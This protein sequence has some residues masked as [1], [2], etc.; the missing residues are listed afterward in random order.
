MLAGIATALLRP[1]R[2]DD[3]RTV[4]TWSRSWLTG[5]LLYAAGPTDTVDYPPWAI[6]I[7]TPLTLIPDAGL[8]LA[9]A[10]LHVILAPLL[11]YLTL[12]ALFPDAPPRYAIVPMLMFLLWDG[13]W[14]TLQ[15]SHVTMI[16]ALLAMIYSERRPWLSGALL[17]LALTKPNIS[18]PFLLWIL[19]MRRYRTAA[20]AGATVL[21]GLATFSIGVHRDPGAVLA[22][23]FGDLRILYAGINPAVGMTGL[24]WFFEALVPVPA[25]TAIMGMVGVGLAAFLWITGS[26]ERRVTGILRCSAPTLACLSTLLLLFNFTNNMMILILPAVVLLLYV[27]DPATY[28]LRRGALIV[29]QLLLMLQPT[30]HAY[31]VLAAGSVLLA[32]VEQINRLIV[33]GLFVSIAAIFSRQLRSAP[34][35]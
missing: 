11:P 23:Y 20:V 12:R 14:T 1:D 31:R 9:W 25:A 27:D 2:F 15:F 6:A 13:V 4:L 19:L 5:Q 10:G 26:A 8:N 7:F 16:A 18:G 35:T 33:L 29:L 24:R 22:A 30:L 21:A 28:T 34:A 3:F 17:G 32:A